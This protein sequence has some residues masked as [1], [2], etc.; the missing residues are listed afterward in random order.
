[1]WR[2]PV[3]RE[4]RPVTTIRVMSWNIESLGDAKT[5]VTHPATGAVTQSEIIN[6]INLA[7]READADIV[8]IM[9]VKASRGQDILGYLLP[10]LNNAAAPGE[11]WKG[12]VSARQDG[13]TQEQT[14]YVWKDRQN[15]LALDQAG[16]PAPIS[17][18][19]VVDKNVLET[20]YASLGITLNGTT[21]AALL[22]ALEQAGYIRH[23]TYKGRGNKRP[24]TQTWRVDADKWHDLDIAMQPA[25]D[26]GAVQPPMAMSQ[27]Q[28]ETLGKQLLG[29]DIL[30][31]I[32]YGDRSPFLANFLI[33]S[34]PKQVLIGVLHAPGP[35]D[36]TRLDAINI[37]GLSTCAAS[38]DNFVL[39]GDFNIAA[40]Q[41]TAN[42]P[43]YGRFDDGSGNWTFAQLNPKKYQTIFDPIENAPVR[44]PEQVLAP[45]Q[46]TTVIKTYVTDNTPLSTV[47]ANTFD[48]FFFRGHGT[49]A[50][51]LTAA[52]PQAWNMVEHLDPNEDEFRQLPARSAL[53]FF[54]AFRGVDHVDKA[55][56]RLVR[57][58]NKAQKAFN[59]ANRAATNMQA[60]I[61]GMNPR[62]PLSSQLYTRLKT[63]NAKATQENQK[64]AAIQ[65]QRGAIAELRTLVTGNDVEPSGVGTALGIYRDAISDHFPITLDLKT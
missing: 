51:K 42:A 4:G 37:I 3:R 36:L 19:G 15:Y 30:R 43:E 18:I 46:R 20:T 11:R 5:D 8:G 56:R 35:Q 24:K 61:N 47:L 48:K 57:D 17:S 60:K 62:P 50:R 2:Q 33:G 7:I 16:A 31:F 34:P 55:D 10:R 40:T 58:H 45:D 25:V 27:Q 32:T 14:L 23:G 39:M 54:R 29:T 41:L 9:E 26:F 65:I 13:G 49:T 38:S 59:M 64:L 28:L 63:Q 12:R 1:M 52:K 44:A 6:F 22:T 21:Q 53:T